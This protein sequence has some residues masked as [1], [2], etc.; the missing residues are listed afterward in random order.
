MNQQTFK[1]TVF[2]LK[3][4]LFRFA[5]SLLV[6][7]D[8]AQDVVQEVMLK[9]WQNKDRL[10]LYNNIEAFAVK[11]IKNECLN[12]LKHF[13]ITENYKT[14]YTAK[15]LYLNTTNNL[16]EIIVAMI[17]QLP[18]KQRMVM[19]LK[20]V[21]EYQIS[22]ISEIL[23]MENNAVR[24]NLMRAR[25]KIRLQLEKIFEHEGKQLTWQK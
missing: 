5:T 23:D 21:E 17:H 15:E 14:N 18:E 10:H 8:E 16:E 25:Q 20:D 4:K 19:H 9:L 6:S 7:K 1:T 22:E 12:R 3:D 13:Q 2:I 11:C 24:A